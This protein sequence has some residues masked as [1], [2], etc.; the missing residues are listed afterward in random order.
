MELEGRVALV[1][2]G[3]SGIGRASA[4]RLAAEGMRVC[5]VDVNGAAARAVADEVGGLAVTADVSDSAQVD[6][7]FAACIEAFGG[8]DLALLNAGIAMLRE[9]GT[10]TDEDYART[11]GVNLD[12][13]VFGARA[14]IRA[15]RGRTDGRRGGLIIATASVAGIDPTGTPDPIYALTKHG[16]VGLVRAL[17]PALAKEGIAVHAICPGLT[18]TAILP[19]P[20]KGMFVGMGIPLAD[21]EQV[22]DAVVSAATAGP[23]VSGT[24]WVVQPDETFAHEFKDVPGPHKRLAQS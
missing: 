7:A 9:L 2:G 20:I 10:L 4:R 15:I 6:A 17:G 3:G 23:E 24:C 11:R 19:D 12:G 18:D 13:V 16:V 14:A 21:P 1:T 8:V 22:A 5:V